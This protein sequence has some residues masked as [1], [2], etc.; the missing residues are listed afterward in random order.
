MAVAL[1][2]CCISSELGAEIDLSQ[3]SQQDGVRWDEML[4]GEGGARILVSVM[5]KQA[6]IWESYLKEHLGDE[7]EKIG[8]VGSSHS[9]L[10]VSTADN[11]PVIDV[12]IRDMGDCWHHA[13]ERRLSV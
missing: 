1:A 9:N 7:W 12:S 3:L 13:I 2:E 10:R 6:A 4:F 11:R 5:P 8:R